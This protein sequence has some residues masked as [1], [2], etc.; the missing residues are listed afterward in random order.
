MLPPALFCSRDTRYR[1]PFGAVAENKSVFFRICLPRFWGCWSAQLLVHSD[2]Q[3]DV[4]DQMFW[5][6]MEDDEHEWWDCT[7]TPKKP[8][9]Y[10]YTF[11]MQ[12]NGGVRWL[13]PLEN[14]EATDSDHESGRFQLTCYAADFETPHW[15]A[16]GI[17][18]Q[19]FPDRFARSKEKKIG[20]PSDRILR[21]DWGAQPEWRPDANGRVWNNDYFG[22]DLKGIEEH[23]G[24]LQKL[25][26]TTVYLNPIFEAHS[27]HRYNTADYNQIDPLLGTEKSLKSLCKAA[28][29]RGIRI[30]LDGVFSHTGADSRYFNREHRYDTCGAYESM[31]SP[32]FSWYQF[33]RWP[34]QY[35]SWWGFLSLPDVKE[36]DPAFSN[37]I[38]GEEGILRRWMKAGVSGWRLDVADELP[39]PFIDHIRKAVKAENDDAIV[40]GEVW[41]DASNKCSYGHQRRYLLGKQLDSVMN[42]P[43]RRAI[44][45]FVRGG[46]SADFFNAVMPILEHYPPQVTRVLM[47]SLGT[48]DTERAL[49]AL[50]GEQANMRDRKWQSQQMLTDEAREHGLR[51]MK[52]AT[53]LQYCLP[54]VPCIYYGD[55]AGM[56][57][58]ADPF[59]RGCYPWGNENADLLAWHQML[60]NMR[61]NV[62]ALTD[63]DFEPIVSSDETVCFI[64]KNEKDRLLCAVNRSDCDQIVSISEEWKN[65]GTVL[66]DGW[67]EDNELHLPPFSCAILHKKAKK[68]TRI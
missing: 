23:L 57:G 48:H 30:I 44:L 47:N 40:I 35:E 37:F 20:V 41:E 64:R 33:N 2:Q 49:T 4:C 27:N 5:A 6:G 59:N 51:L 58:Y 26:V 32:Y 3:T 16:G 56:E 61:K 52:L 50:A 53:A 46:K 62:A 38:T 1:S 28:K 29:K 12:T 24:H 42:Y 55:E 19:I 7:F 17:M 11:R 14:G 68:R 66:G 36:C 43:F 18:Y 65:V 60:G 54:G 34:D 8:G 21:D 22:G 15:M 45:S 9:L 63:G 10:F 13:V 25:G 31:E 39:D 67:V